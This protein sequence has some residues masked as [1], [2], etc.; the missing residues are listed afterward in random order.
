MLLTLADRLK[1][2][3]DDGHH[4]DA[5]Q[6]RDREWDDRPGGSEIAFGET[7]APFSRRLFGGL[8]P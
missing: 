4:P 8:L 3:V 6:Q 5:N 7:N 1:E 2:G